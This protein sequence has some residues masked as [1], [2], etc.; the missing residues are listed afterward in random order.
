[1]CR[2]ARIPSR[3]ERRASGSGLHRGSP[4]EALPRSARGGRDLRR[5]RERFFP[6]RKWQ[7]TAAVGARQAAEGAGSAPR[8]SRRDPGMI[9]S[10]GFLPSWFD[11]GRMASRAGLVFRVALALAAG[12]L[13]LKLAA[14]EF[15]RP[16]RVPG[17]VALIEL[18]A[19][20]ERSEDH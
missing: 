17:G 11:R 2:N 6:L 9:S 7:D 5:R 18:G 13:A 8:A 19:S 10:V 12:L 16:R 20:A 3:G 1:Q 14:A 15:P 4:Q